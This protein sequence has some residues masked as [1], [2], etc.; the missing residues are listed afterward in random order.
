MHS[1]CRTP[2]ID[3]RSRCYAVVRA[4]SL[5]SPVIF[6]SSASYWRAIGL[7]GDHNTSVSQS[8]PSESE[9]KVYILAAGFR[10][11]DI[12]VLP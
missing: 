9:A 6:K 5:D 10:E 12:Q 8:F 2:P 1:P 3:L 7:F 4:E 11:E